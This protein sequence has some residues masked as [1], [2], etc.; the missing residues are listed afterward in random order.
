MP[1]TT[2][3]REAGIASVLAAPLFLLAS[4]FFIAE[5]HAEQD[6]HALGANPDIAYKSMK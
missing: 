2:L 6:L 3:W 1:S 5:A 4:P